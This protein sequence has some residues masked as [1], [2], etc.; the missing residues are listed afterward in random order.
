M[1]NDELRCRSSA[2]RLRRISNLFLG[3]SFQ[4][5]PVK[6]TFCEVLF[7]GIS[8]GVAK[9]AGET[10]NPCYSLRQKNDCPA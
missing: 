10:N 3:K 1:A 2:S 6:L 7:K 5:V 8:S 4:N 9:A